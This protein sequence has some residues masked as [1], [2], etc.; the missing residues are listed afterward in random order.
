MKKSCLLV[1]VIFAGCLTSGRA[2]LAIV[3]QDF[4]NLKPEIYTSASGTT[5][6][7][8][9]EA[10]SLIAASGAALEIVNTGGENNVLRFVS[11]AGS[12]G[13]IAVSTFGGMSTHGMGKNAIIGCFDFKSLTVTK[14]SYQSFVF[15]INSGT[16]SP[17]PTAS[18]LIYF[19]RG[20]D[21]AYFD[22]AS[23]RQTAT[24]MTLGRDINYR[25]T[26][27]ADYSNSGS[28]ARDVYSFIITNLDASV[29]VYRSPKIATRS[30]ANLI[31][32][33]IFF[34]GGNSN[35]DG[36]AT[37]PYF[38]VDNLYF[39][40]LSSADVPQLI[41]WPGKDGAINGN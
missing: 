1:P 34:F 29:I 7:S 23:S 18:V 31:P 40:S 17:G 21:V 5:L 36:S 30:L 12:G 24:V 41:G 2:Q 25:L 38:E 35:A 11:V 3:A 33:R 19:N 4:N 9:P 39:H 20:V 14:G 22:G 15:G 37:D 6:G 8:G 27:F 16:N 32:D 10:L 13:P 26:V 28:D